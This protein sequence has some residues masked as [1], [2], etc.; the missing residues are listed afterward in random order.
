MQY[1]RTYFNEKQKLLFLDILYF[2]K[3][4]KTHNTFSF[5]NKKISYLD[6]EYNHTKYNERSVE[7]PLMWSF[8]KNQK[9]KRI[10]EL[11]N[12]L[13]Q[14]YP[15]F[16]H[17][18]VDK[19]EEEDGVINEDIVKYH[20]S[21]KFDLIVSI[22]TIEHIGWDEPKKEKNKIPKALNHLYE[23]LRP[24]GVCICS[25]PIGYNTYLDDHGENNRLPFSEITY[26]KRISLGNEWKVV[27]YTEVRGSQYGTPFPNANAIGIGVMKKPLSSQRLKNKIHTK[28]KRK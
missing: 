13:K 9:N 23:L 20:P 16:D 7:V 1:K 3:T 8:V 22:S 19:Y 11:G 17:V 25:F 6:H 12:V 5:K 21:K 2:L 28:R 10:L 24:G 15:S 4:K 26:L 18:I 27:P 14:Y